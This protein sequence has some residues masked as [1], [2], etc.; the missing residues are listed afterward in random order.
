M[1]IAIEKSLEQPIRQYQE[2]RKY[3][4]FT[5]AANELIRVGLEKVEDEERIKK[6]G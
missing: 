1:T 5:R 2:R 3:A 4:T 6:I